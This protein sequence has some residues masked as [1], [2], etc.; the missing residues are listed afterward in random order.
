MASVDFTHLC[1]SN[2]FL[3]AICMARLLGTL[4]KLLMKWLVATNMAK[5]R[6]SEIVSEPSCCL[7]VIHLDHLASNMNEVALSPIM[8]TCLANVSIFHTTH[9]HKL[10]I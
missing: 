10:L 6:E 8:L 9:A 1:V 7:T 4:V 5:S 2:S 3:E